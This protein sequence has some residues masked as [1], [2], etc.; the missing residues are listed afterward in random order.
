MRAA[1]YARV[2]TSDQ[3]TAMQLSALRE[4]IERRGWKLAEE[5]ID[6]GVSGSRERR[7]A[8]DR[9]TVGTKRRAFDACSRL[10]L[11]PLCS[12]RLAPSSGARRVPRSRN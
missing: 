4:Y 8:L 6:E 3:S 7:P 2:S 12:L 11:R 9:L 10:S 1:I 5:Y